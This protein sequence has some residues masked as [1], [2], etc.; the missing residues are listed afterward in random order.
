MKDKVSYKSI[1]KSASLFGGV[2]FFQI[3]FSIL[4]SKIIAIYLG[5]QGMGISALLVSS[6]T[7][8][9]SV[10]EFGLNF[11]SVREISE[12]F[13][14]SDKNLY[15][16]KI[17]V[18][19]RL[20]TISSLIGMILMII[21]APVLSKI[22]FGSQEYVLSFIFLSLL[23]LFNTLSSGMQSILQSTKNLNSIA[24][25]TI[26]GTMLG[27]IFTFPIYIFYGINGIVPA[28][29]VSSS[30][31]LILNYFYSRKFLFL[32]NSIKLKEVGKEGKTM[33]QLG[34]TMMIVNLLG[35]IIPFLL[36]AYI[37][38]LGS[39]DDVGLY[40][41][42]VSLTSQYVGMVFAAMTVDYF[43]KISAVN[44]DNLKIKEL[45]NQQSEIML[46]IIIP[47]ISGLIIFAPILI[48]I[49]LSNEFAVISDFVRLM[50]IGLFFQAALYSIGLIPFS[51]GD[52]RTY[53][54]ISIIGNISWLLF[55]IMGYKFF[56]LTGMGLFYIIHSIF[57]FTIT[58]SV[59]VVKYQFSMS[60][61][62]IRS[63]I[64]GFL[65]LISFYL[66][67][68]FFVSLLGYIINLIL[69]AIVIY[70]SISNLNEKIGLHEEYIKFKKK[71]NFLK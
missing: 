53:I 23:I 20:I 46:L 3:I 39:L 18:F 44:N 55:S 69:F 48:K 32:D 60:L 21:L 58:L 47:L 19:L 12:S 13:E 25:S 50:S 45:S 33:I 54:S 17:S 31:L 65:S 30:I 35:S 63:I 40:Q 11:S 56:G 41:A 16:R 64:Y 5:T 10:T 1:F 38:N 4:R 2:K 26:I 6:A 43:P 14:K 34:F 28:L 62:F 57:S 70:F 49:L 67:S 66:I 68:S 36:N 24:K 61:S 22:S 59:I 7:M 71:F 15:K 42:G 37:K 27:V 52:K 9:Q 51:K 8:L 29:L